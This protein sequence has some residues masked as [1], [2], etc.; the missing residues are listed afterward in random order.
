[1][2]DENLQNGQQPP[3]GTQT[4]QLNEIEHTNYL[5]QSVIEIGLSAPAYAGGTRL[6]NQINDMV[7]SQVQAAQLAQTNQTTLAW[8]VPKFHE[9]QIFKGKAAD[10]EPFLTKFGT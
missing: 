9:P 1:M 6:T 2:E 5:L 7:A 4:P 10:V 3:V 8:S